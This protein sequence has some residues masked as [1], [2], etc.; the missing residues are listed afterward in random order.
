MQSQLEAFEFE[1]EDA[2]CVWIIDNQ[3]G[4]RN[5][6]LYVQGELRIAR[7]KFSRL[8]KQAKENKIIAASKMNNTFFHNCEKTITPVNT[9]QV[10]ADELK[11]STNTASRIIQIQAK[12][13][14]S[15]LPKFVL[16]KPSLVYFE[17]LRP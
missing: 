11:T 14:F 8:K 6:S 7:G 2:A 9:T 5:L 13:D 15:L 17:R 12:A 1:D 3:L 4:R 16:P 10:L